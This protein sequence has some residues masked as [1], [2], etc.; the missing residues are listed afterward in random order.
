MT[1]A[2]TNIKGIGEATAATIIEEMPM[3]IEDLV[4]ISTMGNVLQTKG[5]QSK[6]K[7]V[8]TGFR[9]D[10]LV[11]YLATRGYDAT[12]SNVTKETYLVITSD[13]NSTSG[14]MKNA[15]KYDIPTLTLNEFESDME[16]YF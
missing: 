13:M 15:I 4:Y 12:K 6:P 10:E 5:A 1:Y 2:L 14:N 16:S 8:F 7:I 11:K 9:D 3:F